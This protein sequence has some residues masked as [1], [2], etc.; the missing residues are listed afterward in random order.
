VANGT[1][2]VVMF[3][4][5]C[6]GVYGTFHTIP[7]VESYGAEFFV[8]ARTLIAVKLLSASFPKKLQRFF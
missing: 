8:P 2:M 6:V 4:V 5:C 7:T 3:V 1:T